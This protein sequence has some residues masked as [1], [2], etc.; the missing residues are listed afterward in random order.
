MSVPPANTPPAPLATPL[1]G[2]VLLRQ[3][4]SNIEEMLWSLDPQNGRITYTN[5]A[6]ERFW[7]LSAATLTGQPWQWLEPL[8]DKVD[9]R[10]RNDVRQLFKSSSGKAT[11]QTLDYSVTPGKGKTARLRQRVMPVLGSSGQVL[12]VIHLA[13]N[14]TWQLDTTT[15]LR[16]EITRRTDSEAKYQAVVENVNEGILITATGRI[17]YANPKALQLIGVDEPTAKS[18]PFIEFIHLEDRERVLGNHMRR[19]RGEPVENYYHFRVAHGAIGIRWLEISAVLF[20]W[21][22]EPA[23]LN[24]LTDVTAK[25]QA[26]QDMHTALLRE[27]ELSELK[28]RFV[29]VAS[30]EF[31]TPLA[32]ILSSVELL[33]TYGDAFPESERHELLCQVKTAVK[34]MT[35]M[36][37]QVLMTSKLE[38]GGFTFQPTRISIADLLVQV[39]VE[40]E[41]SDAQASR[42]AVRCDGLDALRVADERLVRHIVTNLLG[43]ALKYSPSDLPVELSASARGELMEIKV[44]DQGIGIPEGDLPRL[45]ES[46]H[47]GTNVA[48]IAGTGIGLHIVKQCVDL[49]RGKIAVASAAGQGT[50]FTVQLL[51]PLT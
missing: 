49:H 23:T 35:G 41:R 25:R 32:A 7:G 11:G 13:S 46:F 36:V 3:I 38:S 9:D 42:I 20:Q 27:R 5:P 24:F 26:E 17:L 50:T 6:F 21:Q 28:S 4:A 33:D 48:N 15:R 47:R 37:E 45:F 1:P 10:D 30:H 44:S 16:A 2:E 14:I 31:R 18:R 43:N 12:R 34:R 39:V 22:G 19:M 8:L 51:A 29:A 40:M